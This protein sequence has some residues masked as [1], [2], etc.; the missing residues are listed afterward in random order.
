MAERTVVFYLSDEIFGI[1][2]IPL[3]LRTSG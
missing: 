2:S 3:F 1:V